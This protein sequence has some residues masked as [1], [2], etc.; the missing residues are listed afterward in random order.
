MC[1]ICMDLCISSVIYTYVTTFVSVDIE[2]ANIL[3]LQSYP[4]NNLRNRYPT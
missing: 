3:T 2:A 4:L 1:L